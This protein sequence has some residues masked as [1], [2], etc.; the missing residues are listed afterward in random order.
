M[1]EV[2]MHFWGWLL[3]FATNEVYFRS[4]TGIPGAVTRGSVS[5]MFHLENI[6]KGGWNAGA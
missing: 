5:Q 2:K 6:R 4:L 3:L 1:K